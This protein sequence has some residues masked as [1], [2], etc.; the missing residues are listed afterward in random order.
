MTEVMQDAPAQN[1]S[2]PLVPHAAEIV[3]QLRSLIGE[4]ELRLAE[5]DREREQIQVELKT[6]EQAIRPL[7]GEVRKRG[8][9]PGAAQPVRAEKSK[10]GPERM[11]E[12]KEF[13]LG[14]A[15]DHTEFRQV[16]I[17]AA[18]GSWANGTKINSSSTASAFEALKQEP[19]NFLRIARVEGNSKFYRLT[20][21]ALRM[22]S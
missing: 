22:M 6:Y 13:I 15:A 2:A 21:S 20:N 1:G 4:R 7:T 5:L 12:L 14:Y 3:Q 18:M 8:R 11:A 9:K 17:R 19:E 16:D 10:V